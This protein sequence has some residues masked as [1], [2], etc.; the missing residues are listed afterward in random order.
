MKWAQC[1][2]C[3]WGREYEDYE[4]GDALT[5]GQAC[6]SCGVG[7][8]RLNIGRTHGEMHMTKHDQI[9]AELDNSEPTTPLERVVIYYLQSN[10][11]LQRHALE[12]I[13]TLCERMMD[14]VEK[15]DKELD[16]I[17]DDDD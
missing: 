1:S 8:I 6:P 3:G 13:S 17:L 4:A 7:F 10:V 11:E 2:Q 9:L 14:R 15:I 5:D 16:A 12:M